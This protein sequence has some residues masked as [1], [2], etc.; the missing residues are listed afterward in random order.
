M[1]PRNES[2]Y[3]EGT[4]LY[5]V[6]SLTEEWVLSSNEAGTSTLSTTVL[7]LRAHLPEVEA[8]L[9]VDSGGDVATWYQHISISRKIAERSQPV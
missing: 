6:D 3:L 8:L 9:P 1:G 4:V 5:A 7:Y 2:R